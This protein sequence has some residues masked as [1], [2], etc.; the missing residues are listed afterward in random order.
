MGPWKE[1]RRQKLD[2]DYAG[3]SASWCTL[4]LKGLGL[5]SWGVTHSSTSLTD[6]N[7]FANWNPSHHVAPCCQKQRPVLFFKDATA[8]ISHPTSSL[9]MGTCQPRV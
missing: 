1:N 7:T 9:A 2:V 6:D 5:G 8:D 4:S 3:H